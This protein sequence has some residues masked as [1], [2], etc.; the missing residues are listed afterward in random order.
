MSSE[1]DEP[2]QVLVRVREHDRGGPARGDVQRPRRPLRSRARSPGSAPRRPGP[3]LRGPLARVQHG[4][5]ERLVR[6]PAARRR[7]PAAARAPGSCRWPSNRTT[8]VL[9]R[10]LVESRGLA[11]RADVDRGEHRPSSTAAVAVG[12]G[13]A[14]T[15]A[16]VPRR[17][18]RWRS[19]RARTCPPRSRPPNQGAPPTF[20]DPS[21]PDDARLRRAAVDA[22]RRGRRRRSSCTGWSSAARA[23]AAAR[24]AA[25]RGAARDRRASG[26]EEAGRALDHPLDVRAHHPRAVEHLLLGAARAR[27]AAPPAR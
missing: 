14:A 21:G 22:C 7:P 9:R 2:L 18:G 4:L 8:V 20:A 24:S 5:D 17:A 3:H 6:Q 16:L 23:R 25:G 1:R 19:R 15:S 10:G 27:P 13:W 26:A 11:E 12:S